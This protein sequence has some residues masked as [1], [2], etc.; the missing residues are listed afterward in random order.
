MSKSLRQIAETLF[1]DALTPQK[2][3]NSLKSYRSIL[4]NATTLGLDDQYNKRDV[5]LQ[6]GIA[7]GL[8]WA[9]S[10]LDDPIRTLKFFRGTK[11]AIEAKLTEKESIHLLYAGTGPFATLILP[12][13]SHFSSD[14]LQ[15]TL[16]DVNPTSVE[17]VSQII[18]YFGFQ[19][20][21][22]E[23]RCVDAT[24]MILENPLELDILLSETMQHALQREL[25]VVITSHLFNQMRADA[26]LI[27]QSIEL[28]IVCVSNDAVDI[29]RIDQ[30]L[31]VDVDFL[32]L[33]PKMH[34]DWHIEKTMD[35]S[36]FHGTPNDLLAISTK[37]KVYEGEEIQWNESG[38]TTPKI[39]GDLKDFQN[40]N[41]LVFRYA[42][43][44]E[45]GCTI[46]SESTQ[47]I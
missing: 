8:S 38:L 30:F 19:N 33:H 9:G 32:R 15:V 47:I 2:L 39:I 13:L 7:I 26:I 29:Q 28:D 37:I 31:K 4:L 12:L 17:N 36:K 43:S 24:K 11:R 6:N 16:L 10:C 1:S 42:I 35:F 44:P 25:Q 18:D 41:E 45:P 5:Q 34:A 22:Q 40:A 27:P 46:H 14:Q 21:V 23:I 20:H 3:E